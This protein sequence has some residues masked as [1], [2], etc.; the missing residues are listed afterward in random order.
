MRVIFHSADEGSRR[1]QIPAREENPRGRLKF[2]KLRSRARR[3]FARLAY[4]RRD[5]SRLSLR[6][7]RFDSSDSELNNNT[8][9]ATN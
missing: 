1:I 4:S 3:K 5:H 7:A 6:P 8:P 2:R 9:A